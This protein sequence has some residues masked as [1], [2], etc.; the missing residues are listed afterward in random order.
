MTRFLNSN[1]KPTDG[2]WMIAIS[3]LGRACSKSVCCDQ[4]C[5]GGEDYGLAEKQ[6]KNY[7]NLVIYVDWFLLVSV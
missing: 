4:P 2:C 6:M 5:D 1:S 7:M 3:N